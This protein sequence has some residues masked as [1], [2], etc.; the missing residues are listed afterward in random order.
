VVPEI[1]DIDDSTNK[2]DPEEEWI[3]KED[4]KD[5][6]IRIESSQIG[7]H[8]DA[9]TDRTGKVVLESECVKEHREGSCKGTGNQVP[10]DVHPDF[11]SDSPNKHQIVEEEAQVVLRPDVE[12]LG[13]PS[14]IKV[15]DLGKLVTLVFVIVDSI[16]EG[17]LGKEGSNHSIRQEHPHGFH[18]PELA[19]PR[20]ESGIVIKPLK[21]ADH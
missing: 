20:S 13:E 10:K 8:I 2:G 11:G 19:K 6:E 17:G 3:L 18:W 14:R 7:N 9:E 21:S 4:P 5:L 1:V 12:D 15:K 16:T